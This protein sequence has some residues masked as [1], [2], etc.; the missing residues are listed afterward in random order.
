[1]R[2][3]LA[4]SLLLATPAA[5]Q[6]WRPVEAAPDA[7]PPAFLGF[8]TDV[9]VQGDE[10]FAG[11][12]GSVSALPAPP[13]HAGGVVHFRRTASGGWEEVGVISAP[14]VKLEDGFG[15]AVAVNGGWLA[16]GAPKRGATGAVY[17]FR[18]IS[19]TWTLVTT[20]TAPMAVAGDEFGTAVALDEFRV[21]VGAPGA[22]SSRGAVY[23]A[24]RDRRTPSW[25]PLLKVGGGS[26]L[27]DRLGESIAVHGDRILAGAPGLLRGGNNPFAGGARPP[28]RNGSAKVFVVDRKGGWSEETVLASV[29]DTAK[30]FGAAVL[31]DATDAFVGAP[32]TGK[33]AGAV[34]GFRRSGSTWQQVEKLTAASPVPVSAY[35]W[36]LARS[37]STL[38]VGAPSAHRQA[39]QVHVVERGADG[40]KERQVLTFA[41][42]SRNAMLG[43]RLA[44]QGGTLAATAPLKDNGMGSL[45]VFDRGPTGEW[46]AARLVVDR[47]PE[48]ARVTGGEQRCAAGKASA[49]D[50]ERVDLLSYLPLS[51]LGAKRGMNVND[52]WGW[53]DPQSGR[54]YALVGRMD[55]TTFVDV[56]DP[57]NPRVLGDLPMHQGAN[58]NFWRDIKVYKDHAFIVADGS[59]PHGMQVFDLTQ[60]RDVKGGPVVFSETAHY[61]RIASAHNIAINEETGFAYPIGANGGGETCGGA[62]HMIDIREPRTPKFAGCFADPTTG[63]QRTGYTHDTQCVTY[64]GPDLRYTGREVC[65]NSSETAIGIA[66]VT[67]KQSPKAIATASYPNVTYTHQGWL[68]DDQ[69]YF[70]VDDEG[71]EIAGVVPRTRTLV[72]DVSKLDEPVLVREFLGT[73]GASDH[74]LYVRGKYMFQSNYVAGL[75]VIDI[76]DPANP[77][78]TAYFDTV[79]AGENV[80]GF[81]GS[82][83]NYPYFKSGT[84]VVS[85][86]GEGL[87]VLRHRPEEPAVP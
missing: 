14:D 1:M 62:L 73:T 52:I 63:N 54:E 30:G 69:K 65:F 8:A 51:A 11:R 2:S 72:W 9:A 12:T 48:L 46:G 29:A 33:A 47:P 21:V 15:S 45:A 24:L 6:T 5:A 84:I 36:S 55:G 42:S 82:W 81:A 86:I 87:F 83:S 13:M 23:A 67:D 70:F 35:G 60:L 75:R 64:R 78:E 77:K 53:T 79:P 22:D 68:T 80:A 34:Y 38:F 43:A 16:V 50:C 41:D 19:G 28:V 44:A 59:G 10:M 3:L 27:F 71:D 49:F 31:L 85:S 25:A 4:L 58:P 57:A 61:D 7:A 40:W 20:L 37:G 74:N 39:G 32:R 17:L 18:K 26:E 56:T 76:S 66:D